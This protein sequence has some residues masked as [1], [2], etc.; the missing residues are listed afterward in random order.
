M[1]PASTARSPGRSPTS[2]ATSARAPAHH[3]RGRAAAT[4]AEA[5]PLARRPA[6]ERDGFDRHPVLTLTAPEHTGR[7]P[8]MEC[9]RPGMEETLR[10]ADLRRELEARAGDLAGGVENSP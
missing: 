2:A 7:R 9:A 6:D 3:G 10:R 5:G 1:P 4:G 8:P